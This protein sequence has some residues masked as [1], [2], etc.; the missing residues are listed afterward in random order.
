MNN[1]KN[2]LSRDYPIKKRAAR[3]DLH[4]FFLSFPLFYWSMNF[5]QWSNEVNK[6]VKRVSFYTEKSLSLQ[7]WKRYFLSD[8][9][10]ISAI[11]QYQHIKN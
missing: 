8:R 7:G 4:N 11:W 2:F 6:W 9:G 1:K 5:E 10:Y 3:E